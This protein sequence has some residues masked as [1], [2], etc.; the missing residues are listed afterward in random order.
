MSKRPLQEG[1]TKKGGV[2]KPPTTQKPDI[3]PAPQQ[4]V[5]K[6]EK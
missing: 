5:K 1:N 6:P 3:R 4:P 2:N